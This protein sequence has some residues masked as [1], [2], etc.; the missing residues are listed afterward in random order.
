MRSFTQFVMSAGFARA[1]TIATLMGATMLAGPPTVAHAEIAAAAAIQLAQADTSKSRAAAGATEA[2]GETVEQRIT[3][4]H[5][6][7]KITSDQ[8]PK[9]NAVAQAMR[10]NAANMDKLIAES[11]KKPPQNMTAVDDLESYRKV[12]QAVKKSDR[13]LHDALRSDARCPEESRRRRVQDS[14]TFSRAG[15]LQPVLSILS[16]HPAVTLRDM[17]EEARRVRIRGSFAEIPFLTII[18][19]ARYAFLEALICEGYVDA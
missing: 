16:D 7:L 1:V 17:S 3:N 6:T 4:L 19:R 9:W 2:Q 14:Q 15:G 8:E 18:A 5:K 10:E 13:I 12:A 11:R